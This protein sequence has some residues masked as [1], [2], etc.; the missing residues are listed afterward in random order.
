M[1]VGTLAPP[2]PVV[3]VALADADR[4]AGLAQARAQ[5]GAIAG[6]LILLT[7]IVAAGPPPT[8]RPM[9]PRARA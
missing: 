6:V 5:S 7:V 1:S 4:V 2:T 9:I 8:W 3:P